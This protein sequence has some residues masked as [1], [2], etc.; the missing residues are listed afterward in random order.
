MHALQLFIDDTLSPY[1]YHRAN[2]EL[3]LRATARPWLKRA[4]QL[5][6]LWMLMPRS[7]TQDVPLWCYLLGGTVQSSRILLRLVGYHSE[8]VS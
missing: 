4:E 5:A 2:H 6:K 3:M 1:L 7:T 8:E